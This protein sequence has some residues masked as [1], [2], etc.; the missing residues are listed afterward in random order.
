MGYSKTHNGHD[1]AECKQ[2]AYECCD[3]DAR[4]EFVGCVSGADHEEVDGADNG[5][6]VV[7]VC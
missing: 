5:R 3:W 4:A 2:R 7:Y 6:D 1:V